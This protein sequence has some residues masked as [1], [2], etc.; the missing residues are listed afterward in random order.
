[1]S[2]GS[3]TGGGEVQ[4][5][6][7]QPRDHRPPPLD[8]RAGK[9]RHAPLFGFDRDAA[10]RQAV[11]ILNE[12]L[13]GDPRN[14]AYQFAL[15]K[16]RRIQVGIGPPGRQ[17]DAAH[18]RQAAEEAIQILTGLIHRFPD[19]PV[20]TYELAATF[21]RATQRIPDVELAERESWVREAL[22]LALQL[23]SAHA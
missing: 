17:G 16:R 18:V 20:Y 8:F 4:F 3:R 12:L 10:V 19:S 7:G 14:A 15:A 23:I 22:Q 2:V 9:G 5:G 1:A 6:T 11:A 13:E 21:M